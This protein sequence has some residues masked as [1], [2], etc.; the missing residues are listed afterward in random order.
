[1]LV[2]TIDRIRIDAIESIDRTPSPTPPAARSPG[3]RVQPPTPKPRTQTPKKKQ[4]HEEERKEAEEAKWSP[5][6]LESGDKELKVIN[7]DCTTSSI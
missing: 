2:T 3:I 6:Q 4:Q 5:R 1:M 7:T